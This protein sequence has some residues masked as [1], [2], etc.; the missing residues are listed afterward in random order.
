[1]ILHDDTR[2]TT[3]DACKAASIKLEAIYSW[4]AL[5]FLNILGEVTQG[6]ARNLSYDQILVLATMARIRKSGLSLKI[7]SRAAQLAPT[8]TD[9]DLIVVTFRGGIACC[10]LVASGDLGDLTESFL[11]VS[12]ASVEE[13]IFAKLDLSDRRSEPADVLGHPGKDPGK[14][15]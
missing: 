12:P 11:V 5:G 2:F 7:A 1:M 9:E 3:R 15:G 13:Q 6:R 10:R 14:A 8:A 4:R